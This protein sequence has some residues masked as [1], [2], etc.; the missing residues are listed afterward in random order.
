MAAAGAALPLIP[1]LTALLI[2]RIRQAERIT[3][4]R[5]VRLPAR[6]KDDPPG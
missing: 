5:V 1:T 2:P 6:S 3:F 4:G